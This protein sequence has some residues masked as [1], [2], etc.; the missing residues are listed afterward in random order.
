M[1]LLLIIGLKL[2][3]FTI[4]FITYLHPGLKR[5]MIFYKNF[6]ISPVLLFLTSFFLDSLITGVLVKMAGQF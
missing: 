2:L 5:K 3:F 4:L 6:G 1:S